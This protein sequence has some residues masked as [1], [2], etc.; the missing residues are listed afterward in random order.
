[1]LSEEAEAR[2]QRP[3]AMSHHKAGMTHTQVLTLSPLITLH[4]TQAIE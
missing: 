3:A 4:T 2:P 1:M